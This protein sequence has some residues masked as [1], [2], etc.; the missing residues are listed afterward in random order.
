MSA[1]SDRLVNLFGALALGVM[2]RVRWA[3]VDKMALGGEAAA[4][5]IVIGHAPGLS[6]DQLARVLPAVT[7]RYGAA[8]GSLGELLPRGAERGSA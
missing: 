1:P 7:R 4:A 6:V 3:T 2:D 8:R 5:L